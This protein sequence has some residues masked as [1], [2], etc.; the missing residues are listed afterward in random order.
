MHHKPPPDRPRT[1]DE[2]G[3]YWLNVWRD[4]AAYCADLRVPQTREENYRKPKVF[5]SR[6][7]GKNAG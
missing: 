1:P 4:M 2:L 3:R 7:V 5:A 6:A